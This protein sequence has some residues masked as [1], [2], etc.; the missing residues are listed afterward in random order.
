MNEYDA[1]EPQKWSYYE[2]YFKSNA[3]K[4]ARAEFPELD[5][6]VATQVKRGEISQ[7]IDIRKK[8]DPVMRVPNS[9]KRKK[10][11]CEYISGESTL[12]ECFED[13]ELLGV[14]VDILKTLTTIR[15]KLNDIDENK[16]IPSLTPEQFQKCQYEIKK[17]ASRIKQIEKRI[18]G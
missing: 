18:D 15:K 14:N 16:Q 13:A 10:L 12:D 17:I 4:K 8:L 5:D 3:I 9:K 6:V 2:E 1:L 7:G 11:I